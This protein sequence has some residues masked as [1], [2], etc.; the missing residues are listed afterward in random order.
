MKK[1]KN[2]GIQKNEKTMKD[3]KI[4]SA[5]SHPEGS[6]GLPAKNTFHGFLELCPT[7]EQKQ[8]E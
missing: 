7:A 6:M 2:S 5:H 4:Q 1:K 3:R 8:F